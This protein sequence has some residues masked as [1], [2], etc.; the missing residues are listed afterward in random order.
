MGG[1]PVLTLPRRYLLTHD[2]AFSILQEM[3]DVTDFRTIGHLILYLVDNIE[4]ARLTMKEQT[5]G[6]SDV[7]LHFRVDAGIAPSSQN[8]GPPYSNG[9][10]TS[11]YKRRE[12]VRE[13]RSCLN[14]CEPAHTGVCILNNRTGEDGTIVNLAVAL[15][16]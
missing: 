3:Y 5:I 1:V 10:A 7:L 4:D 16:S 12:I 15:L 13:R 6:I 11:H 2:T 9:L 8:S 14:H